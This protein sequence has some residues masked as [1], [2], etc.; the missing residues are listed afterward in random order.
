V[1]FKVFFIGPFARLGGG[2][3][4]DGLAGPGGRQLFAHF[5]ARDWHSLLFAGEFFYTLGVLFFAIDYKPFILT[6]SGMSWWVPARSATSS[7]C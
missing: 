6:L 4:R 5:P 1:V 3:S 7:R 2:L